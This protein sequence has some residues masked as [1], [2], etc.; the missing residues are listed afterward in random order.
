MTDDNLSFKDKL[1]EKLDKLFPKEEE[2][3][4]RGKALVLF[5]YACIFHDKEIDNHID[6]HNNKG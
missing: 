6:N 4:S 5:A 3:G 1:E 2:D